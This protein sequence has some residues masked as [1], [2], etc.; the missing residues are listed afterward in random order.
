MS[1]LTTS[2]TTHF[3]GAQVSVPVRVQ[4]TESS[5]RPPE[6]IPRQPSITV[7]VAGEVGSLLG[8]AIRN[9]ERY[10]NADGDSDTPKYMDI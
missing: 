6:L 2:T 3:P 1:L 10:E 9:R 4:L 7:P 5:R 8:T